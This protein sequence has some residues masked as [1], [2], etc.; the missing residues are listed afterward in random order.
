MLRDKQHYYSTCISSN[1]KSL[2]ISLKVLEKGN[3]VSISNMLHKVILEFNL[4]DK[5]SVVKCDTTAIN[6]GSKNGVI[7]RLRKI[8]PGLVYHTC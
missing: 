3:S 1:S 8:I 7:K 5:I 2:V 6:T 4:F